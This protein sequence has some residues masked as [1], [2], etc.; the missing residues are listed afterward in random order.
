[1][2]KKSINRKFSNSSL[3]QS[4]NKMK[5]GANAGSD[6]TFTIDE[7]KE[8]VGD[9]EKTKK[10]LTRETMIKI[11]PQG[12][13]YGDITSV[14]IPEEIKIIG[15]GCFATYK[16]LKEVTLP[17]SV[18][19][20]STGAF[21]HCEQLETIKM[22]NVLVIREYAFHLCKA[23]KT[24]EGPY[25]LNIETGAFED[26]VE[27]STVTL[28]SARYFAKRVFSGCDKLSELNI[29]LERGP[30]SCEI[31]E[32]TV[33][34]PK[35]YLT[36]D[37]G[38]ITDVSILKTRFPRLTKYK[39]TAI[40]DHTF[41]VVEPDDAGGNVTQDCLVQVKYAWDK[42]NTD[43]N[44][45]TRK[46]VKSTINLPILLVALTGDEYPVKGF[47]NSVESK[48]SNFKE[49]AVA[50]HP[51]ALEDGKWK[52]VR[53]DK[54]DDEDDEATNLLDT[55]DRSDVALNLVDDISYL[56]IPWFVVWDDDE[57]AGAA[58][59]AAGAAEAAGSAVRVNTGESGTP[60]TF[61]KLTDK[62]NNVGFVSLTPEEQKKII[63]EVATAVAKVKKIAL[64][65]INDNFW[66]AINWDLEWGDKP[67]YL[68][69]SPDPNA[70]GKGGGKTKKKMKGGKRFK[71]SKKK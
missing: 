5:G 10:I 13:Q 14:I 68:D 20:I 58:E 71:K 61:S 42:D 24:V 22:P 69:V 29:K 19:F 8:V 1:M 59:A 54:K 66:N 38:K 11:L 31:D 51:A 40:V 2:K 4:K 23:L 26:C 9:E 67:E 33:S 6:I 32:L 50:Q 3:R 37:C 39:R 43:P 41:S 70:G 52:V 60:Q 57:A 62:W 25:V 12:K 45:K 34:G 18:Q 16:K 17:D 64:N 65:K 48:Q 49:L 21:A 35:P 63:L 44:L 28:L 55:L 46:V 53:L 15:P 36:I 56:S 47:L 27:L 7:F 30:N